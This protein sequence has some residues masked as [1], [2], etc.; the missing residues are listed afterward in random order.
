MRQVVRFA[1]VSLSVLS[2]FAQ[3]DRSTITGT[4]TDPAGAVVPNAGI[5]VRNPATGAIFAG[6]TSAT[7]NYVVSVPAGTYDLT[8]TVQGFKKYTRT[9]IQVNAA[10]AVRQDVTLEVGATSESITVVDTA[11]AL[12]TEN[13]EMSTV[14]KSDTAN[15]LPVLT[16]GTGGGFGSIR[17]PLAVTSLLPGVQYADNFNLRVNGLPSNTGTIRVEGQDAT[18]GIWRHTRPGSISKARTPSRKSRFTSNT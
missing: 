17:N 7:G 18:N 14:V 3:T 15:Q 8:V 13:A 2:L 12:R 5:E 10:S 4:V 9:V 16:I 1:L 6:G 11:P